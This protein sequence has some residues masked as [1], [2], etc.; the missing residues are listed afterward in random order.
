M[1]Q[2]SGE[3]GPA[4]DSNRLPLH[5]NICSVLDCFVDDAS[6]LP[7]FRDVFPPGENLFVNPKTMIL[8]LPR[9]GRDLA[10]LIKK[11]LF[12]ERS[13]MA[14]ACDLLDA[15]AHVK[16]H[17]IIHRDIKADNVLARDEALSAFVLTDLGECF[18]ADKWGCDGFRIEFRGQSRGGAAAYL[19]PEVSAARPGPHAYIDHTMQDEWAVGFLLHKVCKGGDPFGAGENG[20]PA[21]FAQDAYQH[22]PC[23]TS[24]LQLVVQRL[25]TVDPKCRITAA[26]ARM[27]CPGV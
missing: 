7:V 5:P 11:E 27:L 6:V 14:L 1:E 25:L 23:A 15:V 2:F 16:K 17:R 22:P 9:L 4:A 3:C 13:I 8:V 10:T 20:D 18:D 19:S 21:K 26:E 12:T 24:E